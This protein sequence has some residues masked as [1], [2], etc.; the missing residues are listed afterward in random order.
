MEGH[1]I[2]LGPFDAAGTGFCLVAFADVGGAL[3]EFMQYGD[4]DEEGWF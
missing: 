3:V 1:N 2:L 4:P